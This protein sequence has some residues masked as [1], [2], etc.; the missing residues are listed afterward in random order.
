M[1]TQKN[2]LKSEKDK[3]VKWSNFSVNT[4]VYDSI[5][6]HKTFCYKA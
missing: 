4:L 5:Y 2:T 3:G 1:D 6:E